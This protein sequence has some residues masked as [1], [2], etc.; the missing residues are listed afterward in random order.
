M[1]IKSFLSGIGIGSAILV[2]SFLLDSCTSMVTEEQLAKL[3]ELRREEQSLRQQI[4]EKQDEK[5]SLERELNARQAELDDCSKD[6]Q[7]VQDKLAQWPDVW[8][9]WK[10]EHEEPAEEEE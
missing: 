10:P 7:F 3:D 1:R 6:K 9:D 4:A 2:S 5:A 8:P